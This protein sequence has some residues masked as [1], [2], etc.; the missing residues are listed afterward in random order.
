MTVTLTREEVQQAAE[1]V[2][3]IDITPDAE[4]AE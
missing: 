3:T 2:E 4:A 1:T